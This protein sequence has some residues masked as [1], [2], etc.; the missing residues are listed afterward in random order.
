MN[1]HKKEDLSSPIERMQEEESN[2]SRQM[3][4]QFPSLKRSQEGVAMFGSGPRKSAADVDLDQLD[5]ET[6]HEMDEDISE[7][8]AQANLDTAGKM[9]SS[10]L[11]MATPVVHC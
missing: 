5:P 11:N 1:L 8:M 4:Q 9:Q 3:A 2:F 10:L 7:E 6:S